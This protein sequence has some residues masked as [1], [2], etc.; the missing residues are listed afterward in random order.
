MAAETDVPK[1]SM[2]CWDMKMRKQVLMA[3]NGL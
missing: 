2:D 3:W 1:R